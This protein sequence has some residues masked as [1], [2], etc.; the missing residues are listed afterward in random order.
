MIK[1][2]LR[3]LIGNAIKFTYES[4]RIDIDTE[5]A[6]HYLQISVRD[7]GMGIDWHILSKLFKEMQYSAVGTR[8]EK[9]RDLACC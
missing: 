1:L 9:V 2:V 6:H 3:N 4:G 8:G 7:T 5:A